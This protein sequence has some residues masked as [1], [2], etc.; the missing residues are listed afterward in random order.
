MQTFVPF[1]GPTLTRV[2]IITGSSPILP[3][4]DELFD[5]FDAITSTFR[6]HFPPADP[7]PA[8]PV[9]AEPSAGGAL[10][11]LKTAPAPPSLADHEGKRIMANVNV[12]YQE[13]R[14]AANRLTRGKE[15]ITAKLNESKQWSTISST[16]ATSPTRPA[17][18]STSP[19]R[20]STTARRRWPRDLR[21][22]AEYLTAAADTFEQADTELAK[23]LKQ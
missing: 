18:S 5:L 8:D 16:V 15:D 9:P 22:W 20:S 11:R 12:T 21:A 7:V 3:L 13:M 10:R 14:D 1:P 2:A 6:F 17:S 19:T 4:A 23:A